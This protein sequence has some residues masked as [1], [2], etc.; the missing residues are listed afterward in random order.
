MKKLFCAV[1][2]VNMLSA[3]AFANDHEKAA[4]IFDRLTELLSNSGQ[5]IE[6]YNSRDMT[7][8]D[9]L[10]KLYA[11]EIEELHQSA[12]ILDPDYSYTA[13]AADAIKQCLSCYD[14]VGSCEYAIEIMQK[15][16]DQLTRRETEGKK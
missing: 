5:L 7:K 15:A 1:F 3:N 13:I 14:T 11:P 6:A 10:E 8:C 2:I 4:K 12:S 9:R 16:S